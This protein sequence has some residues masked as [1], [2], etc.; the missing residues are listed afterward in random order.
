M[1]KSLKGTE[2]AN[3]SHY[4]HPAVIPLYKSAPS[5]LKKNQLRPRLARGRPVAG[6]ARPRWEQPPTGH[7]VSTQAAGPVPCA[8]FRPCPY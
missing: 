1:L 8:D 5:A 7:W 6:A 4:H 2:V 3:S